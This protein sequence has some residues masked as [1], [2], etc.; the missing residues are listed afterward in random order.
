M[1]VFSSLRTPTAWFESLALIGALVMCA[2]AIGARGRP[3]S[4]LGVVGVI[5]VLAA[6]PVAALV[7]RGTQAYPVLLITV[8]AGVVI[9]ASRIA[10]RYGDASILTVVAGALAVAT[11]VLIVLPPTPATPGTQRRPH[12]PM[13]GA[14]RTPCCSASQEPSQRCGR[15]QELHGFLCSA[16]VAA[17]IQAAFAAS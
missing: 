8:H 1:V 14:S 11:V 10:G 16:C 7:R 5:G 9:A 17:Q 15:R 13:T 6:E 4:F 12:Q 2:G 3:E